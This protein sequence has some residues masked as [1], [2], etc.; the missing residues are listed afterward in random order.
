M[1]LVQLLG[2]PRKQRSHTGSPPPHC[3]NPSLEWGRF[4]QMVVL[5][6]KFALNR[7][8]K[9]HMIKWVGTD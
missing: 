3:K 2:V 9:Y 8:A 7:K 5:N 4:H 6:K 1:G